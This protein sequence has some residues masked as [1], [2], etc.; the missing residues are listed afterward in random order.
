MMIVS[1]L[2]FKFLLLFFSIINITAQKNEKN[3]KITT[4]EVLVVKSYTPNL[5]DAFK[6]KTVAGLPDSLVTTSK[7]LEYKLKLVPVVSLFQPNKAT[8]L[9]LQ[10]RSSSTPYNTFFSGAL[11]NKNQVYYNI[12]SV[13]EIDRTQLYGIQLYRDGFGGNVQNTLLKSNQ[14]HS[15]FGLNHNLRSNE[16]NANTQIQ[17][18]INQNNYFGLYDTNWNNLLINTLDPKIKRSF[19]KIKSHWNW[20]DSLLRGI[21]FQ[22][23]LNSDNYNTSEQ[24]LALQTDLETTL[25]DGNIKAEVKIQG[26]NTRF[27]ASFFER[28]VDEYFQGLGAVDVYWK[29]YRNDLKLKIGAGIT[30]LFGKTNISSPLLYYPQIEISYQKP[31][32]KMSPFFALDGGV[33]QNTYKILTEL[34]PYLAPTTPLAPTFNQFNTALGVR[35]SLAYILNFD[36]RFIFD[37]I[38]NFSYFQRLPYDSQYENMAYRLSNSFQSQYLDTRIYGFKSGI[39]IDL[40]K[41][42]FVRFEMLY[43]FFDLDTD[44]TLWNIPALEMNWESQ[45]KLKERLLFSLNGNLWGDRKVA[46]R[47]IFLNQDLNSAQII[48]ENLPFF[49]RTTAHLTY[50]ITDQFDLF[51]KGRLNTQGIHGRWAYYPEPALLLIAGIT[52]KFD[53]KY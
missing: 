28:T 49:I 44:Q 38:E 11:G 41:N 25:G 53:F 26:F 12:S 6:I 3:S 40:A 14:N 4:Q 50:K 20:Y 45:I 19:F 27:N 8:P 1:R 2:R 32:Y 51:I 34:N 52:Y 36:L 17:I 43:R 5:S 46:F 35:S 48:S 39:R 37:K 16:Y 23:N 10:Q 22:I 47:P 33:K 31:G 7:E 15:R 21:N 42:N 30:Y 9:K 18:I 29:N 24:Q 13:T